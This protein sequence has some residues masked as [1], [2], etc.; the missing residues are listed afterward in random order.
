MATPAAATLR[1]TGKPA[2]RSARSPTRN[3]AFHYRG[4][5]R[6]PAAPLGDTP[7]GVSEQR[8]HERRAEGLSD[9]IVDIGKRYGIV[10]INVLLAL[11]SSET[12]QVTVARRHAEY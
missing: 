9:E 7:C 6:L 4:R 11:E 5:E 12:V 8:A 2:H 10:P 3:S 1:L